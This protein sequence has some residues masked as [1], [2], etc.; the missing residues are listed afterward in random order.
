MAETR[1]AWG[2]WPGRAGTRGVH[3]WP[4]TTVVDLP[5]IAAVSN[6]GA[7]GLLAALARILGLDLL[8]GEQEFSEELRELV[9][10]HCV[11]GFAAV[12]QPTVDGFGLDENLE[13]LRC[14]RELAQ[15]PGD[16]P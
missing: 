4:A 6:W 16:N 13:V 2:A 12:P 8:P 14:L 3:A 10:L 9:A 1:L 15:F 11:D 7:W 5:I